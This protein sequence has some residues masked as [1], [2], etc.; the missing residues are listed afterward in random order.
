MP[1]NSLDQEYQQTQSLL[2]KLISTDLT[3]SASPYGTVGKYRAYESGTI[4]QTTPYGAVALWRDLQREYSEHNTSSGWLGFPTK[5][6]Y[7][8]NNGMRTDFEGGYIY[9]NGQRA[10]A[11]D[12][13]ASPS[14]FSAD[15]GNGSTSNW[16]VQFWN[17]Q[18]LSGNPNWTRT[19]N[20]GELRFEATG[21]PVNTSGIAADHFSARWIT[22]SFFD[23]GLY[24]F[25]SQADDGIRI[26]VDGVKILDRWQDQP[27]VRNDSYALIAKGRHTVQV[28]YFENA[29]S[30]ANTLRWD[31]LGQLSDWTGGI[32][33]IGFDGSNVHSTYTNTFWRDGGATSLG[34]PINNVHIWGNGYVQDF[35]GGTEGRGI[36]MKSNANDNSYW[37]GGSFWNSYYSAG[38]PGGLLGYPISDRYPTNGGFR[39]DFQGGSI[40]KSSQGGTYPIYGGIGG[41]YLNLGAQNSFL[42]FPTSGEIGIGD[43][44][45]IQNFEGGNIVYKVGQPTIAYDTRAAN[46]L[47]V[48][49]GHGSTGRWTVQFW[50]NQ[51]QTGNPVWSRTDPAGEIRFAAGLGAPVNTRGVQEDHFSARW[52]TQSYFDGGFYDFV[53]QADDGI[54]I[55]IDGIK[56]IDKWQS[57]PFVRN[58]A[59]VLLAKGLHSIQ[60]DYFEDGGAAANTLRWDALG[61]G[62]N[63]TGGITPVGFDGANVHVTYNNSFLRNGGAAVVGA[64]SNN[65][66]PWGNGYVQDFKGGTEGSGIVMKSNANDNSYWIGGSF[67]SG[68]LA[69]GGAGGILGYPI[70]DRYATNGGF[71]QDFQGGSLI[72][73]AK[74][75]FPLFGG[76]GYQYLHFEGGQKG[77]LGFPTSGEIGI[78][79]GAIVQNFEKGYIL[80]GRGT[81]RTVMNGSE[82][83]VGY[84]GSGLNTTYTGT[85]DRMGGWDVVG[86][87]TNNVHR[88]GNGY[89]QDFAGGSEGSGIIM[90]W[91]VNNDSHWL[92]GSFWKKFLEV[93]GPGGILGY[94]TSDRY[95][96]NGGFRQDFQGGSIFQSA[97]GVFPVFG[98]VGYQYFHYE[99][100]QQGRLGFPTSGEIGVGNGAIVQN[101]E[102]GYVLYGRGVTR[103]VINGTEIAIGYD[104]AGVNTTFTSTFERS[105]G[106][107]VTGSAT[108]NVHRWENGYTQDFSGGSDARGAIMKSNAN[109]NS[110][111]VGGD[112]WNKFLDVGG[113]GG[114][115]GYATS[116]RYS[117]NGAL[118]QDFQGGSIF[119]TSRGLFTLYGGVGG[120]YFQTAGGEKGRLG[121]PTSGEQ[122][123]GNGIIRQDFENGY[124]LWNG[125]A[126]GYKFDG[127]L[128]FAPKLNS[129]LNYINFS[130]V[131]MSTNGVNLRNTPVLGDRT[132]LNRAYNERVSFDA[133]TTGETVTD[134]ALGTPDNRWFRIAG[135]NLWVPSGYINGNPPT[136]SPQNGASIVSVNFS[137]VVMSTSGVNL[138]NSAHLGDRNS[139]NRGYNE[140]ISFDA[141]TTGDTV[142]DLA[143]GT[144]DN[145]WF[146]IAGTSYWV[147]S[148][149]INGNPPGL[150]SNAGT[151]SGTPSSSVSDALREAIIGQESGYNYRSVNPDS[152]ALG[153]A[154]VM[155]ANI[156]SWSRAALGYEISASQFLNSPDLQIRIINHKLNQYYQSA[157]SAS[158]GNMDTAVRRV[159]SAW[160]SG[161]PD[162]YTLTNPQY[163]NGRQYPSIASY[164]LQVLE[165]FRQAY[166]GGLT[167]TDPTNQQSSGFFGTVG[168]SAGI[169]L[170]NS[171][172]L[173]DRS[174]ITEAYN[175]RLEFDDWK[176]GETVNDIWTGEADARWYKIKGTNYWVPSAYINGNA[177]GS[178]PINQPDKKF[179]STNINSSIPW[180]NTSY[181]GGIN[182][183]DSYFYRDGRSNDLKQAYSFEQFK[184][185]KNQYESDEG[186]W[187]NSYKGKD[188]LRMDEYNKQSW[189]QYAYQDFKNSLYIQASL[190][191][192]SGW[193]NAHDLLIYYLDN[194]D[195]DNKGREKSIDVDELLR[196]SSVAS[197]RVNFDGNKNTLITKVKDLVSNYNKSGTIVIGFQGSGDLANL[198]DGASTLLNLG[199]GNDVNWQLAMGNFDFSFSINF[200]WI[201]D[202]NDQ[203]SHTGKI[204]T[205]TTLT[206]ADVYNFEIPYWKEQ[207]LHNVGLAQNF[208]IHGEKK[209]E[210]YIPFTVA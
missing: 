24:D 67:W 56:I 45:L 18:N 27:F 11:Y 66:H 49:S 170:R 85:F 92:G 131:V 210:E 140:T 128:L 25:V 97:K 29:G 160:Y 164:T 103:T 195:L 57:Q 94:P 43:G 90:K 46:G 138:R 100:A 53:S 175:K 174:N 120:Y 133:W 44:W 112:F 15:S 118:R 193:N 158:G 41:K 189:L 87:A 40:L 149:Y 4:Y 96:T 166:T 151:Y 28:D 17:N 70:S 77:R 161:N 132:T 136:S 150:A 154:Q 109:N 30:A 23:G 72:Q 2:G 83:A 32:Q 208:Y 99:G 163:S 54:R 69:A 110:Y 13:A 147:P 194:K 184:D 31:P 148:G 191:G 16:S 64:P 62:K 209:H 58:D 185:F 173:S 71:R 84:D 122:G 167:A 182:D 156:P 47:P 202:N 9:W 74:G 26:Y 205:T 78:G 89:V 81:T 61:Q 102:N 168:T 80:Y 144:P 35:M 137:G 50:N 186:N 3:A 33:I 206:V 129:T 22:N 204:K 127:S 153:F 125:S 146:R 190:W 135:T 180:I 183:R 145:R 152:G 21:I 172:R 207:I 60:V 201:A 86:S 75:I 107:G 157:I 197:S 36:V 142:T 14:T 38:G 42:G 141:W 37:I 76:V 192:L 155:P 88:W 63:W 114:I 169:T 6:E 181:F 115:L 121:L 93:G 12:R 104:G 98:G 39:Q 91:D 159:A 113:A 1:T 48:D 101:F 171:Q 119:K 52:T 162:Y 198:V 20:A 203:N 59:Y 177:P 51:T 73:S 196:E 123:V 10:I 111:W 139:L 8:W 79:N 105:G 19:D 82:I 176:Y 165:R 106:W 179:D 116:D 187:K 200:E 5:R 95:A 143:L 68:Y 7:A 188:N 134:L 130:G 108:N 126:T 34:A 55:S 65:V 117:S 124:I 199:K 178:F